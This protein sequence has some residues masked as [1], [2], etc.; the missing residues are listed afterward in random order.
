MKTT[1]ITLST[2]NNEF[3]V[4]KLNLRNEDFF[5]I[6]ISNRGK[7]TNLSPEQKKIFK[8]METTYKNNLKSCINILKLELEKW[9]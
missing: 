4:F 3:E 8:D 7:D 5:G 6:A 1:L 2:E 9:I